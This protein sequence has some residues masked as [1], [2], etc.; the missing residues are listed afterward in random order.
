MSINDETLR[1]ARALRIRI[2]KDVDATVRAIV[3]SWARAWDELHATW[4]DAMMDL[5]QASTDGN[6]P[7]PW[8]IARAERAQAALAATMDSIVD[9]ANFTGVTII[10]KV[11]NVIEAVD[12]ALAEILASQLPPLERAKIAATFNRLDELALDAMVNRTRQI[13]TSDT[14]RLSRQAQ[15]QM[16][17]VLIRGVAV[18]DNPRVAAAEMLRRVEGAFNGGLT[19]AM[20]IARTEMLDA[21]REAARGWRVGNADVCTGW[22]WLAQLDRRTCPSCWA[23]H[24]SHH[25]IAEQGPED[26]QQGR[27][28]AV[29]TS[30]TWK[31]LGFDIDEPESL[32]PDARK[33]FDAMPRKDQLAV[34]GPARLK[35]LDDGD[36]DLPHLTQLKSTPGWRDSWVTTPVKDL[37][38]RIA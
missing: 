15:D 27:C 29:P 19:R 1:L 22:T 34:M 26:H 38:A 13:I 3:Q 30:K 35:M 6:W 17:R 9:L 16:R 36:L 10:D 2:D 7:S 12:P 20:V 37:R 8:V 24:G 5:A 33:V 28:T 32:M 25:D 11:G 23:K 4:S 31:Q 18:G 21:H 14:R